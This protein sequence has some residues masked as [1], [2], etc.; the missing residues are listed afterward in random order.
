MVVA[1]V[2]L[3]GNVTGFETSGK[4]RNAINVAG[5]RTEGM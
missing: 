2:E 4:H 1:V 3:Q 5:D